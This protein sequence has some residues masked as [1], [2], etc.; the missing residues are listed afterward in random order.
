M[1]DTGLCFCRKLKPGE[2]FR[3]PMYFATSFLERVATEFL[4]RSHA[5]NPI[6]LPVLFILF[7]DPIRH[8]HH[9]NYLEKITEAP[10]E[11]ELLMVP[12]SPLRLR[13]VV[14]P[15]NPK[16]D[17]PVIVEVDVEPNAQA[18]CEAVP[19]AEWC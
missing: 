14:T 3:V 4:D 5:R 8:C 18:V 6:Y 13:S 2:V 10:G 9:A 15:D 1:P 7:F 19:S 16:W 11:A 12:Y 17:N